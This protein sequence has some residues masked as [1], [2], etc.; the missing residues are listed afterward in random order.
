MVQW[1]KVNDTIKQPSFLMDM[2][3]LTVD[4]VY[5]LI[6]ESPI[7]AF[8]IMLMSCYSRQGRKGVGRG[9]GEEREK[10]RSTCYR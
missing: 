7:S 9:G 2:H 1:F 5:K 6:I 3:G 4:N 8:G 10:R